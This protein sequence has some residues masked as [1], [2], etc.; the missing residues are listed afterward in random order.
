MSL[1]QD[2]I[3]GILWA[4][5]SMVCFGIADSLWKI[6]VQTFG[7]VRSVL[8][9]NF[10]VVLAVMPY[11]LFSQGKEFI[12]LQSIWATLLISILSYLGL[13]FF[14]R[15]I[16]RG[17]TSV[18][19][20]VTGLNTLVTLLISIFSFDSEVNL[21]VSGGFFLALSGLFLLKFNLKHGKL[22][23]VF[24]NDNGLKY[25][26]ACALC[27]GI[28]FAYSYYAIAFTGPVLFTLLQEVT[29]FFLA[30]C[31]FLMLQLFLIR[32]GSP[33]EKGLGILRYEVNKPMKWSFTQPWRQNVFVFILI[34][35]MGALGAIFNVNA[36][37]MASI[38][39]VT[40]IVAIGPVIS[41]LFGQLYYGEKL[42]G[43]QKSAVFLIITGVFMVAYFR[44]Y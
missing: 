24:V 34:G 35:V 23:H 33:L 39:T 5:I 27:W 10:F 36:L 40:G 44:Y 22:K 32:T 26:L 2:N 12:L 15:S 42:T 29:I 7:A 8:F 16:R 13:F 31:H 30:L 43:Q 6:P 19:V 14:A 41:V 1:F 28:S 17:L 9:R 18:M 25:A 37:D 3:Y 38:N 4:L 21:I 20:P 11:F